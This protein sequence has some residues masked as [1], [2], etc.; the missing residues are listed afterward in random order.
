VL[1]CHSAVRDVAVVRNCRP[2]ARSARGS[3]G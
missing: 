2:D 1:R 3:G